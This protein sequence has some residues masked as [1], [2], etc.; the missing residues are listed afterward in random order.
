[1]NEKIFLS[2]TLFFDSENDGFDIMD[3]DSAVLSRCSELAGQ[4]MP[5][6]PML[7]DLAN[8]SDVLAE[9]ATH[10]TDMLSV[11]GSIRYDQD[12]RQQLYTIFCAFCCELQNECKRQ[13]KVAIKSLQ[14]QVDSAHQENK[15]IRREIEKLKCECQHSDNVVQTMRF[16]VKRQKLLLRKFD[17]NLECLMAENT[18]LRR[19]ND[20][21]Q[22]QLSSQPIRDDTSSVVNRLIRF[23]FLMFQDG[24]LDLECLNLQLCSTSLNESEIC[25][26]IKRCT[27]GLRKLITDVD[28]VDSC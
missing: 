25:Q 1:M 10:I 26:R 8:K 17:D 9:M 24:V 13:N 23:L 3:P 28:N 27:K 22:T 11:S 16:V 20:T 12:T 5:H 4:V 19:E 21:L 14:K 7:V 18:R 15:E 2:D 6:P